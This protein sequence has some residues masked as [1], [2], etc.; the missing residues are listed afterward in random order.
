MMYNYRVVLSDPRHEMYESGYCY[1]GHGVDEHGI[2]RT[3]PMAYLA[4]MSAAAVWDGNGEPAGHD[5]RAC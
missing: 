5:K 4:A 1:F 3:M 2:P